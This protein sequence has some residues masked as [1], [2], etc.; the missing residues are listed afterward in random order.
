[1]DLYQ[2]KEEQQNKEITIATQLKMLSEEKILL[3]LSLKKQRKISKGETIGELFNPNIC[4]MVRDKMSEM[5][6]SS[7]SDKKR[8]KRLVKV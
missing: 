1:M 6:Y 8:K 3:A 5:G 7:P 2:T 4:Q